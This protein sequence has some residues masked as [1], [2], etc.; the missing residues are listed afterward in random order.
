MHE[1]QEQLPANKSKKDTSYSHL[2]THLNLKITKQIISQAKEFLK[3]KE[4]I[5]VAKVDIFKVEAQ[6]EQT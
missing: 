2:Q 6:Q 4:D 1:K 3:D 5:L